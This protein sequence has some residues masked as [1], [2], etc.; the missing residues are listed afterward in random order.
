LRSVML[1]LES[2]VVIRERDRRESGASKT[3]IPD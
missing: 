2:V 3:T 1:S